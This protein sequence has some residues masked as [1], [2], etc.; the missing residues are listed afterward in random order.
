[1]NSCGD[2]ILS[3]WFCQK[4]QMKKHSILEFRVF[5]TGLK[6]CFML[7]FWLSLCFSFWKLGCDLC[8]IVFEWYNF[9]FFMRTLNIVGNFKDYRSLDGLNRF[10]NP[11]GNKPWVQY[12]VGC[13]IWYV[14]LYQS[15][16]IR[17]TELTKSLYIII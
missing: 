1:M 8:D 7:S 11:R 9:S 15:G 5:L 3:D 2:W 10:Y 16:F 17:V 6:Y 13:S 4:P 14:G 12:W